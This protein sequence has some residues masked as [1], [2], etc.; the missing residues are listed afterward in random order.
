LYFFLFHSEQRIPQTSFLYEIPNEETDE[1][2]LIHNNYNNKSS[3][4]TGGDTNTAGD[5]NM[6]MEWQI[7]RKKRKFSAPYK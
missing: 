7:L 1:S 3:N 4:N 6:E 5:T 2:E